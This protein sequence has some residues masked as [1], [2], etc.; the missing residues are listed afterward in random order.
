MNRFKALAGVIFGFLACGETRHAT[1]A[2]NSGIIPI[3][4]ERLSSPDL[5]ARIKSAW[6]LGNLAA[7]ETE[8][9]ETLTDQGV[10]NIMVE[11]M[12]IITNANEISA[13][14]PYATML[15]W[16]INHFLKSAPNLSPA[17]VSGI[18]L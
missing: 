17:I 14:G 15:L 2:F 18:Y 10:L 13:H 6:I 5:E 1:I 11:Q 3:C 4:I 16:A 9:A 8:C 7:D 12:E